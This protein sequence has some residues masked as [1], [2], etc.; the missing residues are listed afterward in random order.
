M[1]NFL[2]IDASIDFFCLSKI[3]GRLQFCVNRSSMK[4]NC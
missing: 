2:I 4:Y 1:N 3:V